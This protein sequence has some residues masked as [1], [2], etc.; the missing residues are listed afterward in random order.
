MCVRQFIKQFF[1]EFPEKLIVIE[2][3]LT[4]AGDN[5]DIKLSY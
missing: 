4:A 1:P 3:Q 2:T 5:S